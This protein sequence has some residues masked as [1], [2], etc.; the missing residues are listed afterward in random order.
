[1]K[2]RASLPTDFCNI[3]LAI[4][5]FHLTACFL[6][7]NLLQGDSFPYFFSLIINSRILPAIL[8]SLSSKEN[9]KGRKYSIAALWKCAEWARVSGKL[10]I[11]LFA[12]HFNCF[13]DFSKIDLIR[14]HFKSNAW[15]GNL[16]KH[17]LLALILSILEHYTQAHSERLRVWSQ[18][19]A[20]KWAVIF[21]L[22]GGFFLQCR[23]CD[24]C[25]VQ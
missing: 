18:T 20:M 2:Q 4:N 12:F 5:L 24:I 15:M 16:K 21:L 22:M 23:E 17:K 19:T 11:I 10:Y 7:G 25:E 3:C 8:N 13:I 6:R 9:Q 14:L 1:M